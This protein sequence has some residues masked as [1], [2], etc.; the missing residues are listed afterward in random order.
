MNIIQKLSK[1]LIAPK[2]LKWV[3]MAE[4]NKYKGITF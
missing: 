1:S 4:N 3:Q 2:E